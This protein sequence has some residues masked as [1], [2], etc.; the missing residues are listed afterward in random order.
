MAGVTTRLQLGLSYIDLYLIHGA[1]L[2]DDIPACW[3]EMEKIKESGLA[4]WFFLSLVL[5]I[6]G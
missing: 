1:E 6:E 5:G 4:K 3:K 2:C